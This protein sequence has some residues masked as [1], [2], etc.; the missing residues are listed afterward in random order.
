MPTSTPVSQCCTPE[1]MLERS[2]TTSLNG[3]CTWLAD[4][5]SPMKFAN[6]PRKST[7]PPAV[8]LPVTLER[9]ST[10]TQPSSSIASHTRTIPVLS[11]LLTTALP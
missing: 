1:S 10:S 2:A 5:H 6:W 8:E 9:K 7:P 11:K 4:F 3:S